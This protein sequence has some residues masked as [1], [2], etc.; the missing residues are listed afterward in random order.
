M[1]WQLFYEYRDQQYMQDD[2]TEQN[3]HEAIHSLDRYQTT[4]ISLE[5]EIGELMMGGG[6]Y[7]LVVGFYIP[8]DKSSPSLMLVSDPA[9]QKPF[10]MFELIVGGQA[11]LY[12][13]W[14]LV[15][16]ETALD[17]MLAFY[18]DSQIPMQ[19]NWQVD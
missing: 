18:R 19:Y 11:G 6:Q 2:P 15:S 17:V 12:F 13:E 16:R 5:S 3:V 14:Q 10:Q 8:K 4:L 1:R 9:P 7:D